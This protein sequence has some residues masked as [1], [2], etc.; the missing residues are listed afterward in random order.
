MDL[1]EKMATYA[2]VVE[3]GSFS[4]AAKQLRI[5]SGA[6]SRQIAA[7]EAELDVVL[8][9]R[10]TRSM[11]VTADGHRYY[12]RCLHVLREVA[13]AQS[14]G[15]RQ[16]VEGSISVSAPV[17]FGLAALMPH[18]ATLRAR[19]AA[20]RVEL[21]LDDRLLDTALEGLDLLIR[22]GATIP[23]TGAVI[24]RKL[25]A[26][27]FMLVA[28][29]SYL[30]AHGE[31]QTPEALA[32]H[33]ALSCRIAPGPDVWI[34]GDGRREARV[35]MTNAIVFR[36]TALHGVRDFALAGQGIAMLPA[37][38]VRDDLERGALRAV[39]PGWCTELVPVSAI[40]RTT[41]RDDPRV[42]AVVDYLVE[43]FG[44]PVAAP[45]LRAS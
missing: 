13:D 31:P 41:Q 9:A 6:V 38:F 23:L 2:R 29:P 36:C 33:A 3:A 17:S 39:L 21:H 45:T 43:A 8:L 10:S 40:Y 26:F 11:T 44:E 12:E 35:V 18:V 32:G 42:R 24:A 30:D 20:L 28:A 22:A 14:I 15:K 27:S 7:L 4:K 5:T 37:W 19:Y 25:T 16:G 1:L 34:L